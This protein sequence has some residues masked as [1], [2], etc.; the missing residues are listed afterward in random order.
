MSPAERRLVAVL[1]ADAAGYS[2]LME[3]DE[4]GTHARMMR[5]WFEVMQPSI[6]ALHGQVIK[7]TGDGFLAIFGSASE[8]AQCAL[9][10]QRQVQERE[11]A[12]PPDRRIGFRMGLNVADAIIEAHDIFGDGVNIAAR[13]QT[14]AE[15]GGLVVSGAVAEQIGGRPGIAAVDLGDFFLKNLTRPVRA[16][17]VRHT[18]GLAAS[19]PAPG[20]ALP[21]DR[22]S[23]A[24]LPF[25][26]Q[27]TDPDQAYFAHG[28]IEG[29]VQV[30]SGLEGLFV[31][32]LSST[33]GYG[34]QRTDV[35]A[36]G[37]ELGVRYVLSGSVLQ[38][39]NRL[40]IGTELAD[41]ETGTVIHADR[42]DGDME[43]LFE[44]QDRISTQVVGAIAPHVRQRELL[45]AMRKHPD[46]LTAYDLV[47]QALDQ[48]HRLDRESFARARGLLQQAI[49]H[50][51]G[52]APAHAY[53]AWWHAMRIAQGWSADPMADHAAAARAAA[54][55]TERNGNDALAL[56]V[57]GYVAGYVQKDYA[58]AAQLL[59]HA[60][61]VGPNCALA[62][63]FSGAN[64]CFLGEGPGAVQRAERGLRLSPLDPF[65]FFFEHILSQAHYTNGDFEAAV[66][67]GRRAVAQN[68]RHQPA[69]R[70]LIASLVAIGWQEEACATAQRLLQI[71]PSFSL[72]A[73]AARTP[74][75][76][77]T[78]ELFVERL[79]QAGLPD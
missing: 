71:D 11:V 54:A 52:Y 61:A 50:D 45:R 59:D 57:Q 53:A 66:V 46:N 51:P 18:A 27:R 79:R 62:W 32:S 44:V 78:R 22:P 47:L 19:A 35:R 21:E 42:H 20:P 41:T 5:L 63:A 56:A 15:P 10:I 28:I 9:C 77:A 37:R 75:R 74:L 64:C 12:E 30:L 43:D 8:A 34:N 49:A 60:L 16:Y 2:R 7:H 1:A 70:A 3:A 29:I 65:V 4:E 38:A 40:R 24:V 76:G 6:A 13:L 68:P 55:A 31:I 26:M 72:A 14:Y 69:T 36:V 39:R 73:F 25:R 48:F 67:W 33:L 17:S 23:I 58:A